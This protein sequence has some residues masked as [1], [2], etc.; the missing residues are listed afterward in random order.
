MTF[1][2]EGFFFGIA[3][4]FRLLCLG[5]AVP[6]F[7][8]TTKPKDLIESLGNHVS[9]EIAFMITTA[10]RFIPLFQL[11]LQTIINAQQS[12]AL[13]KRNIKWYFAITIPLLVKS[14]TRAK[15]MAFSIESRGF[16]PELKKNRYFSRKLN[17]MDWIVVILVI[18]FASLALLI[19]TLVC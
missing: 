13:K 16:S 11:E 17:K 7:V 18:V 10:F 3:I 8:M 1:T 19:N 5:L 9:G 14:L 15:Y 6:V 4:A 2:T 12:R